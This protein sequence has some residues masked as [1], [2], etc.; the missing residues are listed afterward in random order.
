M[1]LMR[2]LDDRMVALQRQGRIGFHIGSV[3]EEASIVGSVAALRVQDWVFPCYRE[4]GAALWRGLPLQSYLDNMFGNSRDRVKGRQMPDHYTWREGHFVSVSSPV[5]TQ[6]T[7]A[8]GFAWAAKQKREE[9]VTLVYFGDG[10][11]S[12]SDFHNG[13]NFASVFKA[14]AIF[15][16]RN[17]GWA[18]SVPTEKQTASA[19]FAQKGAAYGIRAVQVDGNDLFA[20]YKATKDAIDHAAAEGG[21]TLI[22]AVTYR[23]GAHSTSDD[24]QVYRDETAVETWRGRDPLKRVR[25]YLEQKQL[26]G[27]MQQQ[28]LVEQLERDIKDAIADAEQVAPPGLSTII[29]DV[30]A[31]PP[32]HLREQ[33]E[34]LLQ[35]ARPR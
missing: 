17:N 19:T 8:V 20:V 10:G 28:Q 34:Q 16:C 5:G 18:I 6:I 4:F 21:P 25:L 15:F 31:V 33:L 1:V 35:G 12:S 29:E 11:T 30:Y 2:I 14:P 9:L 26:W 23:V 27:G 32:W 22:E 24:P 3:G 13:M 7:Q